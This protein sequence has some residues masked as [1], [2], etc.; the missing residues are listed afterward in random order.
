M[1]FHTTGQ[2]TSDPA[3]GLKAQACFK[4]FFPHPC[5]FGVWAVEG[6]EQAGSAP[7]KPLLPFPIFPLM[8]EQRQGAALHSATALL[9][10]LAGPEHLWEVPGPPSLVLLTPVRDKAWPQQ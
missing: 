4:Q 2:P 1:D 10:M 9:L 7:A 3:R 5:S 8:H 6:W